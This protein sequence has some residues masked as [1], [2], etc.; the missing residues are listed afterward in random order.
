MGKKT[1]PKSVIDL[2]ETM[3]FFADRR[4]IMLEDTGFFKNQCTDLP[5][6]MAE[7]PDYLCMI[8]VEDEVDKRS[9]MFKAVQEIRQNRGVCKAGFP[10]PDATGS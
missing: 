2:A 6:Y 3:P 7:L 9:R 8:F 1:E 5:E 10:D 4:V